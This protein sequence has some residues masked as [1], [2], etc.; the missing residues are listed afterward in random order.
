MSN[1]SAQYPIGSGA[2]PRKVP[3]TVKGRMVPIATQESVSTVSHFPGRLVK[4]G[5]LAF[6]KKGK[7]YLYSPLLS[8]DEG[9]ATESDSFLNRFFGGA[10]DLMVLHFVHGKNLSEKDLNDL[11]RILN[12]L[13]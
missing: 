3:K 9:I 8:R 2:N 5:A 6:V 13:E 12:K 1:S 10:R 11:K 4:K 7:S